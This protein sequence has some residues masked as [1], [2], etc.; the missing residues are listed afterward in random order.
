MLREAEAKQKL[1]L[2]YEFLRQEGAGITLHSEIGSVANR[3]LLTLP[4]SLT[5]RE[6]LCRFNIKRLNYA[7]IQDSPDTILGVVA[8]EDI[9]CRV[10]LSSQLDSFTL[11]KIMNRNTSIEPLSA[12]V[13]EVMERLT[14]GL[15]ASVVLVQENG[16]PT[17]VL[18]SSDLLSILRA[19][20]PEGQSIEALLNAA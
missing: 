5:L 16:K 20:V 15:S 18:G 9:E 8:R 6:A 11:V 3:T 12:T 14:T 17:A 19:L 2:C 10:E 4:S 13:L 7:L 1:A